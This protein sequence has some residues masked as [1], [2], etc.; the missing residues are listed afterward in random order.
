MRHHEE[1]REALALHALGSLDGL[2]RHE[3][4]SHLEACP[5]CSIE[6]AELRET[7]AGL[8]LLAEPVAPS[9]AR[10]RR[11]FE[12]LGAEPAVSHV[13]GTPRAARRWLVWTARF[14]VAAVVVFLT[15]SQVN[16]LE[17]LDRAYAEI[18]HMREIGEF[19]TSPGVSVVPLWGTQS[20]PGAHAKLA[21]EHA[22]GRYMLFSSRMPHPAEGKRYQLWVLS[23]HVRHAGAFSPE[24]PAGTLHAPPRAD[25]PFQ[26][27]VSLEPESGETDEPTGD[28]V[29]MSG[30]VQH[31]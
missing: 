17:R 5:G 22:T 10:T 2:E 23:D 1:Y 6:L 26:F 19:V 7:A 15:A 25:E 12:S 21:Y 16:L 13:V 4:E 28:M 9:A 27:A 11:I 29:L 31:P 14:A 3:L 18:A 30:P 8:V 20:V 24:S